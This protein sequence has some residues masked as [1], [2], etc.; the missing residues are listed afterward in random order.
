MTRLGRFVAIAGKNGA[1]KSRLLRGLESVVSA[2]TAE[3]L[4]DPQGCLR[5][6][7]S[8]QANIDA[9]PQAEHVPAWQAQVDVHTFAYAA[10]T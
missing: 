6:A 8:W 3:R 4:G 7:M 5:D 1:G 9:K 10:C 2:R